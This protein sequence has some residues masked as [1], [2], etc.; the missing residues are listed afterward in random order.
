MRNPGGYG[1]VVSPVATP[2]SFDAGAR[3][4]YMQPG[5]FETDTYSCNHCGAVTTVKPRVD[6]ADV[7]A[8]CKKCMKVVCR[9]CVN[10]GR[11]TGVISCDPIEAKLE[12]LEKEERRRRV[13]Y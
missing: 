6:P 5:H 3:R 9:K 4:E 7:G 13:S 10:I 12:R 2:L 1:I 8:L 11:Q